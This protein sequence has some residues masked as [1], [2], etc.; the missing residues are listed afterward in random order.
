[1]PVLVRVTN[2]RTRKVSQLRDN[3]AILKLAFF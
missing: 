2:T 3:A 1:M